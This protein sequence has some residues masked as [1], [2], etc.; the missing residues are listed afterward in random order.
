MAI[1]TYKRGDKT[2]IAE[3]FSASEFDCHGRGCCNQT[4]IDEKLVEYL[5]NIRTHFGKPVIIT[6]YRCPVYNAKVPN[7]AKKSL[8][9]QGMA[10]DFHIDGVAPSEIAKYAE[11]I[12]VLGIG[13]YDTFVHIDTRTTKSFWYSHAQV[14]RTTFGGTVKAE[15][16]QHYT[17]SD[18]VRDVQSACGA[19]VD[20]LPGPETL[21]KTPTVS[22]RKNNKHPVVKFVQKRLFALGYK[23]VGEADG[24]AGKKF[25]AAIT[26]F[27]EDNKCWVDGEITARNKT[28]RKLLGME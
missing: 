5:Q 7:A 17:L 25:E 11:S 16:T 9:M 18:F 13:L 3:N 19:T 24:I 20:G 4:P 27:Q 8:H 12:G 22:A 14:K 28:W 23:I 2:L 6:A 21:S 26:A 15:G 1:K 10:A